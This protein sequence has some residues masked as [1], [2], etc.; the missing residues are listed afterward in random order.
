[1]TILAVLV[2]WYLTKVWYKRRLIANG[3]IL[4]FHLVRIPIGSFLD[5]VLSFFRIRTRRVFLH[6]IYKEDSDRHLHNHPWTTS[7]SFVLW[8]GYR[9]N[10]H[11]RPARWLFAGRWNRITAETYH[12]ITNVLPNTWTLFFAGYR[13]RE[14]GFLVDGQHVKWTTYL[15]LPDDTDLND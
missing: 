10:L 2:T 9:E 12:Q 6:R 7:Q 3:S 14:W 8:G 11:N 13:D 4:R 15:H 5:Y 1:M